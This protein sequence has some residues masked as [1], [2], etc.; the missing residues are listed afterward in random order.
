MIP[1]G[2]WFFAALA[3][4][5]CGADAPAAIDDPS[6]PPVEAVVVTLGT[7][8]AAIDVSLAGAWVEDDGDGHG[9]DAAATVPGPPPLTVTGRRSSWRLKD[10]V[11]VFEDDVR[12]VRGDVTMTCDRLEVTYRGDKIERAHATGNVRVTR[13]ERVARG[14]TADLTV[15]DGRVA[16]EGDPELAE[17]PNRMTG[18]R[19]VLFL[20][21]ER[22]ECEGDPCRL[23]VKG[24]AV[25]P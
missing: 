8:E 9:V 14:A 13:G 22:L 24:D 10:A 2:A 4:P 23:E 1:A 7:G 20:D 19:I 5:G 17:G 21:D 3:L 11:V 12:A 16:I 18:R 6:R 25:T 15:A